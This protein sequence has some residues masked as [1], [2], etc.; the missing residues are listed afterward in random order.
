MNRP[1]LLALACTLI[2]VGGPARALELRA[3]DI[4]G[5]DAEAAANVRAHLSLE[6]LDAAHRATLSEARLD[7]YLRAIPDEAR[8]G[9]EP[10]GY[11]SPKV[12]ARI[13]RIGDAVTVRV[14]I[15]PGAPIRVRRLELGVAGAARDDG[16]VLAQVQAFRPQVGDVFRHDLYEAGKRG[17]AAT[18]EARGYFDAELATHRVEVTRADGA[19][20]IAL[21]WDSGA[22]TAFGDA[23]FEGSPVAPELLARLVP[24]RAGQPFDAARLR[25]LRQRLANLDYFNAITLLPEATARVNGRVP[26]VVSVVPARRSV[27]RAGVRYGTDSGA[28]VDAGLE[29]RWL[30]RRGH[31]VRADLA[32]AQNRRELTGEYRIPAFSR[33][34]GWWGVAATLRDERANDIDTRYLETALSR[35]GRW[36][37][38]NA[39]LAM[40]LRREHF[41]QTLQRVAGQDYTTV[42]YPSLVVQWTHLDDPTYPRR[43]YGVALES[44]LGRTAFGSDLDFAQ[45]RIE[46]RAVRGFARDWRLLGRVELGALTSSDADRFPP[47]LR[48]YAGGDRSLRGYGY[49]DIGPRF[50]GTVIGGRRLA[51]ASVEVEKM[52]TP[53]WG[54]AMFV[55]AGDAFDT[56]FELHR[57]VG[58]GLRWRSPVGPVRVDVARGL[59]GPRGGLRLHLTIGPDL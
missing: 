17:I 15:E 45:L 57:G 2:W 10:L 29:R 20:D 53:T 52:F 30:N 4:R 11:Y 1:L 33:R 12:D 7:Y 58:L 31:K 16:A 47:S 19:A 59:D 39:V 28:G 5:V 35:S 55:D 3:I 36:R 49:K 41:D 6:R 8:A 21:H 14:A 27:Y 42:V 34:E 18:L 38:G 37:G 43:G 40:N 13:E 46:A 51:V 25:D 22:R 48:F 44:R 54:A 9:L 50:D 32:L 26:V 56:R 23:R 24:W